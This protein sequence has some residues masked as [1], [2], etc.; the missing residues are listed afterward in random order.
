[1]MMRCQAEDGCLSRSMTIKA[2]NKLVKRVCTDEAYLGS[3]HVTVHV[4]L[5]PETKDSIN[6]VCL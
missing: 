2:C 5:T 4:R 1:M 6:E 3:E